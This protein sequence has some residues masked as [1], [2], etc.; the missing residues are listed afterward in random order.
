MCK[1]IIVQNER[2]I[3]YAVCSSCN[4]MDLTEE[5]IQLIRGKKNGK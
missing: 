3:H 5:Q 2:P 1:R 4:V